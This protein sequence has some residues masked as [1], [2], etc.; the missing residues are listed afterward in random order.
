MPF[1]PRLWTEPSWEAPSGYGLMFTGGENAHPFADIAAPAPRGHVP[2]MTN[3]KP[4]E[5]SAGWVLMKH[6]ADT[7]ADAGVHTHYNTRVGRLVVDGDRV[8]GAE[9]VTF[10]ERSFV[11]ARRGLVLSAGGFGANAAMPGNHL[12]GTDGDDGSAIRMGQAV[13]AAVLHMEAGQTAFPADPALL[14]RSLLLD[15]HG[16]RFINEDGYPGRAGQASLFRQDRQIFLLYDDTANEETRQASGYVVEPTWVSNDLAELE[17]EMG[18]APGALT[19]TVGLYNAAAEKGEDPVC[20]K[21]AGWVRPLKPPYGVLDLRNAM[22]SIFTTGRPVHVVS[23]RGPLARRRPVPG[24]CAAGRTTS[25][26]PAWGY[27]SGTSLGD[28]TFSGQRHVPRRR[29]AP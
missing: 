21:S 23:R 15:R 6:L 9:V 18:P 26:I 4:G 25:G 3:K 22:F 2:A 11:K 19:A 1:E 17:T 16:N 24:L 13:G 29:Q 10:G 5:Q 20:H 28:S 8:V 27:C 14:Y 7:A 12:T